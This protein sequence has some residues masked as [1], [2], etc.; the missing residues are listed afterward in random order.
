MLNLIRKQCKF[1]TNFAN[2]FADL[3]RAVIC[4]SQTALTP[5]GFRPPKEVETW[6]PIFASLSHCPLSSTKLVACLRE[7]SALELLH[8]YEN[9]F[10]VELEM[11]TCIK[12]FRM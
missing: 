3:F 1:L 9:L 11:L 2:I 4:I 5:T 12:F 8:I 10:K 7:K 6:V